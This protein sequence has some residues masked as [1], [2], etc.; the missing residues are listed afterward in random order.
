MGE[1]RQLPVA[2]FVPTSVFNS[3]LQIRQ[4]EAI[5]FLDRAPKVMSI[6]WDENA[7]QYVVSG[8]L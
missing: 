5:L 4:N 6:K 8:I 3:P 2:N 1:V 7:G